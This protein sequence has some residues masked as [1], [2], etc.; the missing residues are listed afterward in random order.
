MGSQWLLSFYTAGE[1]SKVVINPFFVWLSFSGSTR[2]RLYFKY[3]TGFDVFDSME[4]KG[5][6]VSVFHFF[7]LNASFCFFEFMLFLLSQVTESCM[8]ISYWQI[9]LTLFLTHLSIILPLPN[10]T[11][12]SQIKTHHSGFCMSVILLDPSRIPVLLFGSEIFTSLTLIWP[13]CSVIWWVGFF[14]PHLIIW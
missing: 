5:F 14:H 2:F 3:A 11:W 4:K 8:V 12:K 9:P 7:I 10:P 13:F 6:W 1:I